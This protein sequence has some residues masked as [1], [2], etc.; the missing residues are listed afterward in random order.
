[1]EK[2]YDLITNNP[3]SFL[4]FTFEGELA[5]VCQKISKKIS[6]TIKGEYEEHIKS[7]KKVNPNLGYLITDKFKLINRLMNRIMFGLGVQ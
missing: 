5:T 3:Y 7:G 2:D 6:N 1:M 4:K